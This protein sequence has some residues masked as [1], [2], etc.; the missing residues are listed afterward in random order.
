[1]QRRQYFDN[2]CQISIPVFVILI[3][4]LLKIIIKSQIDTDD[5]VNFVPG[6]PFTLNLHG[7]FFNDTWEDPSDPNVF[8]D[9]VLPYEIVNRYK[10]IISR[11]P[12]VYNKM[13]TGKEVS[14]L[15]INV[16]QISE[17]EPQESEP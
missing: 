16:Q 3:L 12:E 9:N 10:D 11:L 1:L 8:H 6:I 5:Q 2:I 13:K 17:P 14:N 7:A 4:L 15:E